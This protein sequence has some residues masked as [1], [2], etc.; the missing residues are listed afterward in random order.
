M[1]RHL[2]IPFDGSFPGVESMGQALELAQSI[3]ARV[4][5][6]PLLR[7]HAGESFA[8]MDDVPCAYPDEE[9]AS[10]LVA[11]A[12]AAARAQG[13][14]CLSAG[15]S[16]ASSAVAI[17]NAAREHGCDLICIGRH[18][19][20]MNA[21][22]SRGPADSVVGAADVPVLVCARDRRPVVTRATGRLLDQHRSI[23]DTLH[24]WLAVIRAARA[25]GTAPGRQVMRQIVGR[26]HELQTQ[27][28][29]RGDNASLF[30]LLRQSSSAADAELDE[31]ERQ[32]Q[33]AGQILDE[34]AGMV[35]DETQL[36]LS[37]D[38]LEQAVRAYA[39]FVWER[40]GREEGVVL[41]AARRYLC[42]ADWAAIAAGFDDPPAAGSA[43]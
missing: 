35:E 40:M 10:E 21:G 22:D 41:P 13:V 43:A 15:M 36:A 42:E 33:Y 29:R 7:W 17:V 19:Y 28:Y 1:Y 30:A 2:L 5:F 4:T 37:C 3:G 23:A 6:L 25:R 8:D 34:L 26:L 24:G 18:Q 16:S 12:S 38:H 27:R 11:R 14:P 32:D 20:E 9:C 39:Q 31:L